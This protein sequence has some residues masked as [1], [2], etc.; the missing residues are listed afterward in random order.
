MLVIGGGS[1]IVERKERP[2]KTWAT[3][4]LTLAKVV[5]GLGGIIAGAIWGQSSLPI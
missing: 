1:V 4:F 3:N 5:V 2:Y